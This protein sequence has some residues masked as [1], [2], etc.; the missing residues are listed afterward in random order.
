[1][2]VIAVADAQLTGAAGPMDA[3]HRLPDLQQ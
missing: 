2:R 3:F 1:M